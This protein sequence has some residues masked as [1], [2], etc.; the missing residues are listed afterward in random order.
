MD[1]K[2]RGTFAEIGAVN[3]KTEETMRSLRQ[4]AE[5]YG[6]QPS[7]QNILDGRRRQASAE[8]LVAVLRSLGAPLARP[9]DA[10]GALRERRQQIYRR[11][12]DPVAVAW[13]GCRTSVRLRLPVGKALRS[14]WCRLMLETGE[15]RAW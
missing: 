7:Y 8:V 5:A 4:L 9:E 3:I 12:P 6:I 11:G 13:D 2:Q 15:E 1:A 14:W 10:R